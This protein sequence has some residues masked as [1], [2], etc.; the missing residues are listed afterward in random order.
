ML[1]ELLNTK[2]PRKVCAGNF[3]ALSTSRPPTANR[4]IAAA[5]SP[6]IRASSAGGT[7][8]LVKL[9][10]TRH[11]MPTF[12]TRCE[13]EA[14]SKGAP[15]RAQASPISATMKTGA[16]T[17]RSSRIKGRIASEGAARN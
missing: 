16:T 8:R 14:S 7:S 3:I 12:R 17:L 4:L 6:A 11:G 2:G 9:R 10:K 5:A 13:I 15:E 1:P